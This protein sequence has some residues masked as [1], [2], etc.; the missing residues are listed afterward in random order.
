MEKLESSA[1]ASHAQVAVPFLVAFQLEE[2][3]PMLSIH[4]DNLTTMKTQLA[5]H[6]LQSV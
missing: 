2:W 1:S 3:S 5:G 4:Q 6:L